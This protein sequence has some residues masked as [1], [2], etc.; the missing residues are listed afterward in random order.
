MLYLLTDQNDNE[1]QI[2]AATAE[3]EEVGRIHTAS[4]TA[5]IQKHLDIENTSCILVDEMLQHQNALSAVHE[6]S[7]SYPLIPVVLLARSRSSE[8]VVAAIDAGAR[9]VL[10]F[11]LTLEEIHNR[12]LPAIAWSKVVRAESS[13]REQLANRRQGSI[14]AFVSGKGGAGTST[15]ALL[16]AHQLAQHNRTCIVDL[17]VRTGNIAAMAGVTIRRSIVDLSDIAAEI[18]AREVSEVMYPLSGG[19]SLLPAPEHGEQGEIMTETATRQILNLLRYQF[20]HVV[21]DCGSRLDDVMAISLDSADNIVIVA[22]PDAPSLRSVRQLVDALHRLDIAHGRGIK[23]LMNRTSR[24][25]EIQPEFAAKMVSLPLIGHVP[26]LWP[27]LEGAVNS[28]SLL[29][30]KLPPVSKAITPIVQSITNANFITPEH[31]GHRSSSLRPLLQSKRH[32][33]RPTNKHKQDGQVTV[34]FPVVFALATA[35]LLLCL[36]LI[37][38]GAAYMFVNNAAEEAAHAYSIGMSSAAARNKAMENIPEMFRSDVSIN[39]N[40]EAVTVTVSVPSIVDIDVSSTAGII[41][42]E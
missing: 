13:S 6:L 22:T 30:A 16:T 10:A 33:R 35:A 12:L 15:L 29:E 17:D 38:Y 23:L 41:S 37:S 11:P 40:K 39:R 3:V 14:T 32:R 2:A 7:R 26:D 21:L 19:V 34:E 24:K 20:D 5:E 4:D 31:A 42:E 18:S 27:L 1:K 28:N 25:F 36:Q 8:S 9:T